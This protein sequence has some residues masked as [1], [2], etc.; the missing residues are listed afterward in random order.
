MLRYN[1]LHFVRIHI[2]AGHH[3]HVFFA[4]HQLD[5]AFFV[6]FHHVAGGE[7]AALVHHGG[8]FFGVLPIALHDLRALD[9]QFANFAQRRFVAVVVADFYHGVGYG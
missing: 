4:V 3:N 6:H 7:E 8:G 1:I 5:E 2:E 9:A